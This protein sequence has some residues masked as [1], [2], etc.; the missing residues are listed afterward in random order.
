MTLE[1]SLAD[2]VTLIRQRIRD[3]TVTAEE[4]RTIIDKLRNGRLASATASKVARKTAKSTLP[5]ASGD[6]LLAEL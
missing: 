6:D 2:E 5:A 3:N 4:M 1:M